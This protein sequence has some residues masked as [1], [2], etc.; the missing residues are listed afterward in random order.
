MN[1]SSWLE[2][3][4][5]RLTDDLERISALARDPIISDALQ[6]LVELKVV[7][8]EEPEEFHTRIRDI[9][10]AIESTVEQLIEAK[11][12]Q[13]KR[14]HA[15]AAMSSVSMLDSE[16]TSL[17][18]RMGGLRQAAGAKAQRATTVWNWLTS[19]LKPIIQRISA[20]LWQF[21]SRLMTPTSWTVQGDAGVSLF[22]LKG[23]V[24][25]SITFGA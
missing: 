4:K 7:R 10:S 3:E 18:S 16:V 24:G 12:D 22:G 5:G 17:I 1:T 6:Q 11:Q 15:F 25:I 21:I 20:R 14:R 2:M 9:C 8:E 13:E 23:D 19:H